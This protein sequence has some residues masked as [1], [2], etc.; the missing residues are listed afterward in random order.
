MAEGIETLLHFKNC[1]W[2]SDIWKSGEEREG[3]SSKY[4]SHMC[5]YVH[6]KLQYT[7]GGVVH[8]WLY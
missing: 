3:E 5:V 4:F 1:V 6:L 2:M 7:I 8:G